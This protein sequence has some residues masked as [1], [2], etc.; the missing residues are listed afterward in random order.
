VKNAFV[1]R[2]L[3]RDDLEE[4]WLYMLK[5]WRTS[6]ADKYV[7][8]I[9]LCLEWLAANPDSGKSRDDVK[10]GYYCFPEGRHLIFYT[11]ADGQVDVIGI[12]HQSMDVMGHLDP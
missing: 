2:E 3:A 7:R 10:A 6:Q 8:S 9:L 11:F 1:L 12:P 5:H 4:I